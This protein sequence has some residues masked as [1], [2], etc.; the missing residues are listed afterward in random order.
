MSNNI[1]D[2]LNIFDDDLFKMFLGELDYWELEPNYAFCHR[3]IHDIVF[4]ELNVEL[5]LM[6]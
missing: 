1:Y 2:N 4:S 6:L 5:G 3:E